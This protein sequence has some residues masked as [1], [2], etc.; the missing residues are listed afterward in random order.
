MTLLR[1][2]FL[3][4]VTHGLNGNKFKHPYWHDKKPARSSLTCVQPSQL[5]F[6]FI[7]YLSR[8]LRS[9]Y[10]Y[11][12]YR[13]WLLTSSSNFSNS[14]WNAKII[15]NYFISLPKRIRQVGENQYGFG[16]SSRNFKIEF[17]KNPNFLFRAEKDLIYL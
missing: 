16:I 2:T 15:I 8:K 11:I 7:F 9:E 1:K 5:L 6:T 12:F 10:L 14:C 3:Y 4:R 17:L 13:N